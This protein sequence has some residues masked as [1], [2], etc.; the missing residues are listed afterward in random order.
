MRRT[1]RCRF[2]GKRQP[3]APESCRS[4][5]PMRGTWS[6]LSFEVVLAVHGGLPAPH[7]VDQRD[8]QRRD[9]RRRRWFPGGRHACAARP[10]RPDSAPRHVHDRSEAPT[11]TAHGVSPRQP[12]GSSAAE[13]STRTWRAMRM[14]SVIRCGG[15]AASASR[16][17][18]R[19]T[20]EHDE[21]VRT[22]AMRHRNSRQRGR[23]DRSGDPGHNLERDS[24]VVSASASSPPRP[25]TNGSPPLSRTTRCPALALQST[26]D[27]SPFAAP[28]H[29]H[30]VCQRRPA[31]RPARA[32][33]PPAE[34]SASWSTT[35]ASWSRRAA[36]SVR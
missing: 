25:N 30:R 22:A 1:R 8:R 21:A 7:P 29:R 9:A 24:R 26:G 23:S 20:G 19:A 13:I 28:G 35:S 2:V 34:T 27:G 16:S 32:Q 11:T 5:T 17:T 4:L 15:S 12:R 6:K 10:P 33:A 14:T 31:A 3:R 18:D 36:R